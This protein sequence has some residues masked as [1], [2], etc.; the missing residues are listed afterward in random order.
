M[1]NNLSS[2]CYLNQ[3]L[4]KAESFASTLDSLFY[5]S[6]FGHGIPGGGNCQK[7]F[8]NESGT[9][10]IFPRGPGEVFQKGHTS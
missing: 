1:M 7:Y 10:I 9:K 6:T 4:H 5:K 3:E 8:P 2:I